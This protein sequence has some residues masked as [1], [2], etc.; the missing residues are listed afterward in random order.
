MIKVMCAFEFTDLQIYSIYAKLK[1]SLIKCLLNL[2]QY[3]VFKQF[4][5]TQF[6]I[7]IAV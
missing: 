7:K 1:Y 2:V 6:N 4:V 5:I 3:V